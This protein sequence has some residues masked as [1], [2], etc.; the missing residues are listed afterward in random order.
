MQ[1]S[2]EL[3]LYENYEILANARHSFVK[4]AM[5]SGKVRWLT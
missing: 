2:Y 1:K 5:T 4:K 3:W